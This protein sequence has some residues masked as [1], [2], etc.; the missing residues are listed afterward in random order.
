M[1]HGFH[2]LGIVIQLVSVCPISE[3]SL[4]MLMSAKIEN[5]HVGLARERREHKGD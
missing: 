4:V 2:S 1:V 3:A 5:M